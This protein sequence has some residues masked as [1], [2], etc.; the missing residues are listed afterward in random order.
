[1]ECKVLIAIPCRDTIDVD[2][3]NSIIKLLQANMT[4]KHKEPITGVTLLPFT[5]QGSILP[6]S[7]EYSIREAVKQNCTHILFVDSDMTFPDL[8]LHRWLYLN[9]PVIAANCVLR[10][11]PS[12]TTAR[13]FKLDE[14]GKEAHYAVKTTK[15]KADRGVIEE[16]DAVG[17]GLMLIRLADIKKIPEPHFCMLWNEEIQDYKGE[18]WYFC[19][20]LREYKVPI[21][22]DHTVSWEVGHIGKFIHTHKLIQHADMY[23]SLRQ[24]A[25][26]AE[27]KDARV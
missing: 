26:A 27:K 4:V 12:N 15:D 9:K 11:I 6:R 10:K 21:F 19:D 25:L 22:V 3:F 14:N 13:V 7:R 17:T 18:D 24:E 2:C 23:E 1:M 5:I 16:V 8:L 20:K